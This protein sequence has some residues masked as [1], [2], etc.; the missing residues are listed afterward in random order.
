MEYEAPIDIQGILNQYEYT[1]SNVS[2]TEVESVHEHDA[3]IVEYEPV[4]G[5]RAHKGME[6]IHVDYHHTH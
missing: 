6:E 1:E 4:K 5:V 3:F 2:I